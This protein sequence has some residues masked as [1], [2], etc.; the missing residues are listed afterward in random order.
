MLSAYIQGVGILGPGIADWPTAESVLQGSAPYSAA[1]TV[2]PLPAAL[3]P[4]ERRRAGRVIRL[5]L[6]VGAQAVAAAGV[7][8]RTLPSVFSSSG[9][10]ADNC[11]EICTTLASAERLLS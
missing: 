3:P 7:D 8:A 6:G 5:A 2:L 10:D 11:H 4:A 9:G 1:P